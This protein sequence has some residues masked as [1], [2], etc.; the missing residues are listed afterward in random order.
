VYDVEKRGK[1]SYLHI[2]DDNRSYF[3]VGYE[4][5]WV[6]IRKVDAMEEIVFE[7]QFDQKEVMKIEFPSA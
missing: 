1:V 3:A 2:N 4:S 6:E 5:G 7:E